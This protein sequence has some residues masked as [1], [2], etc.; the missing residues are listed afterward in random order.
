MLSMGTSLVLPDPLVC[1]LVATK[2]VTVIIEKRTKEIRFGAA[3]GQKTKTLSGI[4]RRD[5][6]VDLGELPRVTLWTS[7][8]E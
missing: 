7:V 6:E 8:A 1:W 5:V 2:D 3:D 4:Q